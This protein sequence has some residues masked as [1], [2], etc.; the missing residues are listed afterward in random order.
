MANHPDAGAHSYRLRQAV[1]EDVDFLAD[2]VI[3]ATRAQGRQPDDFAEPEWRKNFA[4]WTAEQISNE[5]PHNTTSVIEL[6]GEPVGRLRITRSDERIELSGI[7]LLPRVQ[8]RGIG[9]A[10]IN[11]LKTEAAAAGISV[12][13][14]VEKDNPSARRLYE[15][16]G[17]T[18]IGETEQEHRLQWHP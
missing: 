9:T 2:V 17:C 13:I 15:R 12:D 14:G 3:A 8:G 1:L 5:D 16:L 18:K 11:N 6:D 4:Q 10:I 7:Q